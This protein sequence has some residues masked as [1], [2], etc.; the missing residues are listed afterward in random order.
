MIGKISEVSAEIGEMA[1]SNLPL[2]TISNENNLKIKAS[3]PAPD[4]NILSLG[5]EI[6]VNGLQAK[7]TAISPVINKNGMI[8]FEAQ[9]TE[10]IKNIKA[11]EILEIEIE[12]EQK[13]DNILLPLSAVF[14]K[15][16][17]YFVYL[18]GDDLKSHS[19][20]LEFIKLDGDKVLVKNNFPSKAKIIK[21]SRGLEEGQEL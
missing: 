2:F 4:E 3:I 17:Q 8:D 19:H 13:T 21:N 12:K 14:E 16:N 6:R 1:S 18:L 9:W 20:S 11:G 10:P 5:K 15:D 7:I